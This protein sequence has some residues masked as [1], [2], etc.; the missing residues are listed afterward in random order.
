MGEPDIGNGDRSRGNGDGVRWCI[1]NFGDW[2]DAYIK[3]SS[4]DSCDEG[5]ETLSIL[6][7]N[8]VDTETWSS[9]TTDIDTGLFDISW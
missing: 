6:G 4:M 7:I 8:V 5:E 3:A 9:E 1:D 2:T